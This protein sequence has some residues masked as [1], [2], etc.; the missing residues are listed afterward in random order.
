M[1][2]IG[3][4]NSLWGAVVGALAVSGLDS[5]LAVAENGL[6]IFGVTINLQSGT[7]VVVEGVL[8]AVV[9]IL[10]P[11]G[12]TGGREFSLPRGHWR[13]GVIKRVCVAGAGVIGSLLAGHLARVAEVSV[14]V[15]RGEHA[16]ELNERGLR[17][18]GRSD[19][20]STRPGRARSGR[21]ARARPRDRRLQGNRSGQDRRPPGRPFPGRDA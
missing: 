14:L 12:L 21:A 3:G 8:M 1:L 15:R 13:R 5:L 9:L 16:R 11:S 18:S 2:V 20:V 17:M 10:R 7:R 19:F 6:S 4:T